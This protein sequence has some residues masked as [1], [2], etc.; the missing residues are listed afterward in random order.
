MYDDSI[1]PANKSH[2]EVCESRK[3]VVAEIVAKFAWTGA[4]TGDILTSLLGG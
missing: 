1:S 2:T 4:G 3:F